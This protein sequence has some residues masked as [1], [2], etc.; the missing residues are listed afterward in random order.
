M[1]NQEI[2]DVF[3]FISGIIAL[4]DTTPWRARAYQNAA[5]VIEQLDTPLH[6]MFL[7]DPKF[8]KTPGI[9]DAIQQKLA[10]LFTTGDISAFQEY[11]EKVPAGTYSLDKVHGIG[12]KKAYKLSSIFGLDK[13]ET[14]IS[15]LLT[16]A[17]TGKIRD[18]EGF[19]EK[20]ENDLITALQAHVPKQRIPYNVAK[21]IAD[22]VVIELKKCPAVKTAEVLGSLRRRLESVGDI[23]IGIG[24]SDIGSVKEFV[25]QMAIVKRV[26]VAGDQSMR[27]MLHDDNQVDIKVAKP[28][29]WGSF[30]QHFTGSKEHNIRLRELALKQG[31]SLSEHGIK[32]GDE[33]TPYATEEKFYASLGLRWIPP[34]QRVG[35]EEITAA[36]M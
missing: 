18:I 10:E 13:A 32:I 35:A 33:L 6:E 31:K 2:A 1:S 17:Q 4:H 19:G 15:D 20:S 36:K 5:A 21:P 25:K 16:L 23:D 29:E 24:V 9:G 8:G 12:V 26:V 28:E 34:E 7:T 22:Q 14:A 11:V 30:L 3:N 27:I